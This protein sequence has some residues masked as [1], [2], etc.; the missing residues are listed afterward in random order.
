[1]RPWHAVLGALALTACVPTAT[2]FTY[3]AGYPYDSAYVGYGGYYPPN[4][5]YG[6]GYGWR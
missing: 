3:S 2:E 1:M 4:Y 5:G 6:Y